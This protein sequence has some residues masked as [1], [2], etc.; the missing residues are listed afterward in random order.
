MDGCS[1]F[2]LISCFSWSNLYIDGGLQFQ[3]QAGFN[4]HHY[5]EV[6]RL[7]GVTET[8]TTPYYT[9]GLMNPYGRL[10]LGYQIEF[11]SVTLSLEASHT[12]S[13]DTDADRGINAI[14]LKAR[15][16]PFR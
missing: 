5:V 1:L 13:F 15:W 3:D 14:G 11:K 9:D 12:S 6:K 4:E 2:A 10:A 8:V 16:F 7:P